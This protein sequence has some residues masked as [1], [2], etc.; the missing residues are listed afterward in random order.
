[1]STERQESSRLRTM[2]VNGVETEIRAGETYP[3]AQFVETECLP[4]RHSCE[5][6]EDKRTDYRAALYVTKDGVVPGSSAS[7][8]APLSRVPSLDFP[9]FSSSSQAAF[10]SPFF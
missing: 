3:D 2:F 8:G 1:M 5:L 4:I 10:P 6:A 9:P 7:A